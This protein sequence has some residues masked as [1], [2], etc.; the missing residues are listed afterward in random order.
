MAGAPISEVPMFEVEDLM[1]G[2][3]DIWQP[4][5]RHLRLDPMVMPFAMWR[6][7]TAGA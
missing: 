5:W 1:R 3:N 2:S 7:R 6:V 4:G